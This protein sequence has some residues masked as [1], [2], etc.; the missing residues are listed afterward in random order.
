MKNNL[1]P[2]ININPLIENDFESIKSIKVIKQIEKACVNI[3][4]FQIIGHGIDKKNSKKV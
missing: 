3:G 1:I 2:T 4:F